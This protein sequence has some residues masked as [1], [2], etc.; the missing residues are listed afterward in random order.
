MLEK[1]LWA[2]H[3][4]KLQQI[5]LDESELR[6]WYN[7]LFE[8]LP[9]KYHKYLYKYWNSN[10]SDFGSTAE[11]VFQTITALVP[12][13]KNYELHRRLDKMA[14]ELLAIAR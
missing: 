4:E 11:T 3:I 1:D 10:L 2:G 9:V 14:N 6:D 7:K 12:R 8:L 13:V 5:K